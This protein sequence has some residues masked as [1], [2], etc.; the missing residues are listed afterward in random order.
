MIDCEFGEQPRIFYG[1]F[2]FLRI[3]PECGKFVKADK[4]LEYSFNKWTE[5]VRFDYANAT[6]KIHGRVI[7]IFEGYAGG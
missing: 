4:E 6:C 3:C 5:D 7:M 1:D 2:V